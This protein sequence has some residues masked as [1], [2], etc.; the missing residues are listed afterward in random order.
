MVAEL[1]SGMVNFQCSRFSCQPLQTSSCDSLIP[2]SLSSMVLFIPAFCLANSCVSSL[3]PAM[4][5]SCSLHSLCYILTEHPVLGSWSLLCW[6]E[7]LESW[8][9]ASWWKITAGNLHKK[10]I[11]CW[12]TP[13]PR[14]FSQRKVVINNQSLGWVGGSFVKYFC[15]HKGLE[16][17]PKTN[18]L[19]G[20]K[21][22]REMETSSPWGS[23]VTLD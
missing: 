21:E 5:A 2:R 22:A 14:S 16:S 3:E 7:V 1:K 15:K 8:E 9:G 10:S 19:K 11:Y 17:I 23:L 20:K 18:V 12:R 13:L 6:C 4:E